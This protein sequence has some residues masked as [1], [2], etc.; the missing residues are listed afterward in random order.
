[1]AICPF[2]NYRPVVNHGGPVTAHWGM[3]V[4]VQQGNGSTYFQDNSPATEVSDTFWVGLDGTLEQHLDTD[5]AGWT[6][7]A[8]NYYYA[9][10]EFEGFATAAMTPAQI[11]TAGRL[12][13]WGHTTHGWPLQLCDHGGQG[14][15]THAHYPSGDPDAAWGGHPCPGALRAPQLPTILVAANATFLTPT[16]V[17][18]HPPDQEHDM[19]ALVEAT[20][21][22][23]EG[24]G[25]GAMFIINPATASRHTITSPQELALWAIIIPPAQQYIGE[26][27][28]LCARI[29]AVA[30]AP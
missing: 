10:V 15:T 28:I 22:D 23:A 8:G 4:H 9:G 12:F 14:L 17:T 7:E 2:A 16:P 21:P 19:S 24:V 13:A 3:V 11:T 5:L 6:Q 27:A 30:V 1:M 25:A 26:R 18:P 29:A 20:G